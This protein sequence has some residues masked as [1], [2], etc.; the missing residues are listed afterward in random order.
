MDLRP[1]TPDPELLPSGSM[2]LFWYSMSNTHSSVIAI[3]VLNHLRRAR[4]F[5]ELRSA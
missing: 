5:R 4:V 3:V 1:G 2:P